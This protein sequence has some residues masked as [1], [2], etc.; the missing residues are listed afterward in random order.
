M[1]WLGLT[2][3][4]ALCL[5]TTDALTK[6]YYGHLSP[7]EMGLGR[8]IFS[9][10]WLVASLV[11]VPWEAPQGSFFLYAALALPLEAAAYYGYM[12]AIKISPLSLTLPFLAF[13]PVFVLLTGWLMLNE[14]PSAGALFGIGLIVAGAYCLNLSSAKIGYLA[15]IKAI[16]NEPGSLLMLAVSMIFAVT[17]VLGKLAVQRSNAFLFGSLYFISFT[18]IQLMALP[19]IPSARL[20]RVIEKPLV[21]LLTGAAFAV[22]IFCH[23][24]AIVK[25]D[26]AYMVAVKRTSLLFG[27]LYGWLW[28]GEEKIGERLIGVI[29]MLMGIFIIGWLG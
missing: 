18:G 1:T 27:A 16:S 14:F 7:Y 9:L 11:L 15:P 23:F 13:T 3:L 19:V 21:G 26:A 2:L 6:K 22:M 8:L 12:T 17:S 4:S 29:L 5:A 20:G 25:T 24:L 10:P 28:F